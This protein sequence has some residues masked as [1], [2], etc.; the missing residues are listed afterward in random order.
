VVAQVLLALAY[1][2]GRLEAQVPPTGAHG[3]LR[4][5]RALDIGPVQI[6]LLPAEPVR[7]PMA[8]RHQ[9]GAKYVPVKA[10]DLS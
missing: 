7:P 4:H 2:A 10:F 5:Q 6:E 3:D 8:N 1:R 9:L